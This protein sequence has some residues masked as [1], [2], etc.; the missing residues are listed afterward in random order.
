MSCID[1]LWTYFPYIFICCSGIGFSFQAL[2]QKVLSENGFHVTFFAVTIRGLTQGI[3]MGSLYLCD[4]ER[5]E[6]NNP[7]LGKNPFTLKILIMRVIFG[8]LGIGFAFLTLDLLPV[9]DATVLIMLGPFIAP[10]ISSIFLGE[11][12]HTH[13]KIAALLSLVGLCLVTKPSFLFGDFDD[14]RYMITHSDAIV[15]IPLRSIDIEPRILMDMNMTN[16]TVVN[17][18]VNQV[19]GFSYLGIFYGLAGSVSAALVYVSLRVLGTSAKIN[20]KNVCV[21]QAT[22]QFLFSI[23]CI[24]LFKQLPTSSFDSFSAFYD[25]IHNFLVG[26]TELQWFLLFGAAIIATI[27]Q[28]LMTVGMQRVKSATGTALR[29]TDVISSFFLQYFFTTDDVDILS[30][31]GAGVVVLSTIIIVSFIDTTQSK[32]QNK[33]SVDPTDDSVRMDSV[34]EYL[35]LE[36]SALTDDEPN[37]EEISDIT[38]FTVDLESNQ[39]P[40]I[41]SRG[42]QWKYGIFNNIANMNPNILVKKNNQYINIPQESANGLLFNQDEELDSYNDVVSPPD[43]NKDHASVVSATS[44]RSI[45]SNRSEKSRRSVDIMSRFKSKGDGN[46]SESVAINSE[47]DMMPVRAIQEVDLISHN[48]QAQDMQNVFQPKTKLWDKKVSNLGMNQTPVA[49]DGDDS[50]AA[51]NPAPSSEAIISSVVS[52]P[53][54]PQFTNENL[55]K[56]TNFNSLPTPAVHSVVV[57]TAP[58]KNSCPAVSESNCNDFDESMAFYSCNNDQYETLIDLT[59]GERSSD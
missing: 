12:W 32:S 6:G 35:A 31:L 3:V 39:P 11:P 41:K 20:W 56:S 57:A 53:L 8:F 28:L 43:R 50:N 59:R 58:S 34:N 29:M 45:M 19:K 37:D 26:I 40:A 49:S 22:G 21:L 4:K 51:S 33:P 2:A 10:I 30:A 55:V 24:F 52:N 18:D 23:P 16:T 42:P 1:I 44:N 46:S 13:E 17:I 54:N 9:G 25:S 27:S 47:S 5:C 36:M 38:N 14:S 48:H 7:L 15:P